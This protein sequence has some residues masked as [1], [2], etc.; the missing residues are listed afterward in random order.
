MQRTSTVIDRKSYTGV[1]HQ[2]VTLSIYPLDVRHVAIRGDRRPVVQT[3]E[4]DHRRNISCLIPTTVPLRRLRVKDPT[5]HTEIPV[6]VQQHAID[7][8]MQR[9]C[10]VVPGT[11]PSIIHKAF[12]E[13]HKIIR[14]GDRYLVE[15][16]YYDIKIGYF[17]GVLVNG[18]FV[19][20][21]F[22]FITHSGTPEGRKLAELTGLQRSDMTFLAIDD[23]KT[24]INSDIRYDERIS[25][26]F[27]DAGCESILE[28]NY[29]M[30][31][32]GDYEWLWDDAKQDTELS[33]LIAEYIQLGDTDEEYFENE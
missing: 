6:Y 24:L 1:L 4:I 2:I 13:N 18:I 14:E 11:V 3:G 26:I 9:A 32:F 23:L 31:V 12:T 25:R 20:L 7:R 33:K 15:G 17:V 21:T 16:Y 19:I 28:M 8:I 27:I 5:G 22:L 29:Q 30:H 10:C